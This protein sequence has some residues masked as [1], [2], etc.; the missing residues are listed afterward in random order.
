MYVHCII[1]TLAPLPHT[2]RPR[3]IRNSTAMAQVHARLRRVALRVMLALLA[4]QIA[5]FWSALSALAFLWFAHLLQGLTGTSQTALTFDAARKAHI[6]LPTFARD[7]TAVHVRLRLDMP[8]SDINLSNSVFAVTMCIAQ[9]CTSTSTALHYRSHA[10]RTA[11]SFLLAVPRLAG[12]FNEYQV[13]EPAVRIPVSGEAKQ[14]VVSLNA[15]VQVA[16]ARAS[17]YTE[18]VPFLRSISIRTFAVTTVFLFIP[19]LGFVFV[20]A[21]FASTLRRAILTLF[22]RFSSA[23][24][25]VPPVLKQKKEEPAYA[26]PPPVSNTLLNNT[27][28]AKRPRYLAHSGS[29]RRRAMS[30]RTLELLAEWRDA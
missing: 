6:A 22:K 25:M 12:L 3:N 7:V 24:V 1:R 20:L 27:F 30:P 26:L 10:H 21:F 9:S 23:R 8:E 4:L 17:L 5:A 28:S 2:S 14:V 29:R 11:R 19:H 18:R 13:V 15:P 16:S